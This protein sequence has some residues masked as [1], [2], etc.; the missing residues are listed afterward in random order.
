MRFRRIVALLV[1]A[2]ASSPPA[3]AEQFILFHGGNA[4]S[5]ATY[6]LGTSQV[7]SA[8]VTPVLTGTLA[9][10]ENASILRDRMIPPEGIAGF[11]KILKCV[12]DNAPLRRNVTT[13]DVGN[14]AAFLMSD[15]ASGI[16]GGITYVD[17][18][19]NIAVAG[20]T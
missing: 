3:H 15:L 4:D 2:A 20:A 13:D 5:P 11:G 8:A 16:T 7:G 19:F 17:S 18:G 6:Y 10:L 12:E 14:A 1:C 9:A